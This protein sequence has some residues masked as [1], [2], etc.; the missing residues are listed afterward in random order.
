MHSVVTFYL[1]HWKK[2]S[3]VQAD[4]GDY[5]SLTWWEQMDGEVQNTSNRKF[6]TSVPAAL[7]LLA[8]HVNQYRSNVVYVNFTA[9]RA[10]HTHTLSLTHIQIHRH[11]YI[12]HIFTR[13]FFHGGAIRTSMRDVPAS[14]LPSVEPAHSELVPQDVGSIQCAKRHLGRIALQKSSLTQLDVHRRELHHRP[15]GAATHR[16]QIPGNAW[17][18]HLR[19]QRRSTMI[20]LPVGTAHRTG[21]TYTYI[22]TYSLSHASSFMCAHSHLL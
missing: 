22:H 7:F 18:P 2:G 1:F 11:A 4:Q 14:T 8:A 21:H 20:P 3:P 15:T 9:V 5:D 13:N 10:C 17:C 12:N 6:F 16:G 19:H